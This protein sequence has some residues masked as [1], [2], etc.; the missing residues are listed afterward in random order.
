MNRRTSGTVDV[1]EVNNPMMDG[2]PKTRGVRETAGD[3]LNGAVGIS[4]I[5]IA[6]RERRESQSGGEGVVSVQNYV[7]TVLHSGNSDLLGQ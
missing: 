4:F 5:R 6:G 3:K 7:L 2:P 1:H